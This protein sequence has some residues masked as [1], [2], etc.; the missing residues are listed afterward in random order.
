MQ[1][2]AGSLYIQQRGCT[3]WPLENPFGIKKGSFLAGCYSSAAK[4]YRGKQRSDMHK[5][6]VNNNI[7]RL[8]CKAGYMVHILIDQDSAATPC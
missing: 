3:P 2:L 4:A 5:Q 6:L 7:Y 8:A 1:E